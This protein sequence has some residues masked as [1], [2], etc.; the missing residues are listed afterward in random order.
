MEQAANEMTSDIRTLRDFLVH[1]PRL[2]NFQYNTTV[3]YF[4]WKVLFACLRSNQDSIDWDKLIGV[5]ST[6]NWKK[7]VYQNIDLPESWRETFFDKA[8][9]N[10]HR[11]SSCSRQC[12]PT[13]TVYYC[14]DCTKNPLY[15]ICEQCFDKSK[16]STHR[17]TSRVVTRSEGRVCHCGDPS[18]FT[19]P[20][21]AHKCINE[22]NNEKVDF[23]YNKEEHAQSAFSQVL[24][25]L[26]DVLIYLK[27]QSEEYPKTVMSDT[28]G[29][30]ESTTKHYAL[31]LY[32]D[33]CKIHVLDLTHKISTI[34]NKPLE[35]GTMMVGRLESGH[36]FVTLVESS[37]VDKLKI[38]QQAFATD[39]ISLHLKKTNDIFKEYLIEELLEWCYEICLHNPSL[40]TK[41][42]LRVSICDAWNSNL[43]S[44]KLTPDFLS[45]YI[46]KI[47]LL[48]KFTVP[49]EQ[50]DSFPWCKPWEFS[51]TADTS[52]DPQILEIM[53]N[54]D[55]RLQNTDI[56]HTLSKFHPLH[57]SRF[58]YLLS[59][60]VPYIP[61]LSKF[62]IQKVFC[63]IFTI[64]DD[65]RK[66]LA[67]QYLDIYPTLLFNTVASD[68]SGYQVS[69]M[70]VLSQYIFQNP[71][72]ANMV[73]KCGFIERLLQFT[74]TL[75]SFTPEELIDCPPVPL[76]RGF[77][78][79]PDTIKNK[80]SVICF[81]DIYLTMS[82][83]TVPEEL[84]T[85]KTIIG[86]IV[87]SFSTFDTVLP[88]KREAS[89]HVEFENFEFSSYYFFF[90]SM[91]AMVDG[92]V[93][94]IC[95]LTDPELRREIVS[96]FLKMS[97][98]K[99]F[100]LLGAFRKLTS[101]SASSSEELRE[102]TTQDGLLIVKEKICNV[103]SNVVNYQVG[104]DIQNFFNPMSYFFRF[105]LQW[106]QCGRYE[107]LP[108]EIKGYF[109]FSK[110]FNNK[111]HLIWISESALST[112]VMI[113]Q[114]SVGFWVRNG[115]PITHQLR[116][117]TKYSMREFTYF[118]DIFNVQFS[119]SLADPND[120]MV[121][122]LSRWGL[123][124]WTEGVPM[125]DYP[126]DD[127]TAAMVDQCL[128]LIIRL[129]TE[130]RS[131]VMTSSVEGFE[132]TMQT[133]IIHA[134]CFNSFSHNSLMNSIPE[135][136]TKHPAF[137]LYLED[138]TNYTPPSGLMDAGVYTLKEEYQLQIDP[139]FIGFPPSKR[140][141][142]E[143]MV[144][145]GMA[146]RDG[147]EYKDTFVPPKEIAECLKP[148][149]YSQLYQISN[150]D[151]FGIFLK[152]TLD[153]IN[154]FK[155]ETMLTKAVH[156][157]HLCVI[158]N[159]HGFMKIF[160]RE[161]AFVHTEFS[162]YHSIGSLLY[163]FLLK[164][165]FA[166]EHGKIREIFKFLRYDAPHINIDS[167]L[168][169][170]TP[171][172]NPDLLTR[173]GKE[174]HEKDDEFEKK[175]KLAKQRKKKLMR[176]LAKQ[177]QMFMENNSMSTAISEPTEGTVQSKKLV[178]RPGWSYPADICIF[179]KMP[180]DDDAFVYFSFLENNICDQFVNFSLPLDVTK[181]Y[182]EPVS[183]DGT[184]VYD[185]YTRFSG[186]TFEGKLQKLQTYEN[187]FKNPKLTKQRHVLRTCGHGAHITC[188]NNHMKSARATHNHITK[189]LPI[190]L[191]FSLTFCPLCNA[192]SNC[193]L[194]K[195]ASTNTRRKEDLLERSNQDQTNTTS[196]NV[197][198][199]CIRALIVLHDLISDSHKS[200]MVDPIATLT[201]IIT[202]TVSNIEIT[203]RFIGRPGVSHF[204]LNQISNQN[205]MTLRILSELKIF[206]LENQSQ[207]S[208]TLYV[209]QS[210]LQAPFN[211]K[212]WQSFIQTNFD[213]DILKLV[214]LYL[215]P[216]F[217]DGATMPEVLQ[218]LLKKKL[219]QEFSSISREL[220]K[221]NFYMPVTKQEDE[222]V[223]SLPIT[224]N[225]KYKM[226][227]EYVM[228]IFKDY[229][230][231]FSP[232]VP[233]EF[234]SYL[235]EFKWHFH[236][237]IIKSLTV[238]MRR[239]ILLIH[240]EYAMD[241]ECTDFPENYRELDKLL[242]FCHLFTVQSL[243]EHYQKYELST[244]TTFMNQAIWQLQKKTF[245]ERLD[246]MNICYP[247][248]VRLIDLPKRLSSFT[249][250]EDEHIKYRA[251]KRELAICLF[252]GARAHVQSSVGIHNHSIGEC[253]N[254]YYNQCK[255]NSSYGCFLLVRSGSIYLAYGNRGTFYR[256]PY[257][258]KHGDTDED[259]RFGTTL[260]LNM[261]R[262]TH[263]TRDV[264]LSNMIP[265]LVFRL[266]DNTS[267]LGGW[268]SM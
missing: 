10:D 43:M 193:F 173:S 80:R 262:Y 142:A 81:K 239:S 32:E 204:I 164:E 247:G 188:L 241:Q 159:L 135:H 189:N 232:T 144:R 196:E 57:G 172:F 242:E 156:L 246:K 209:S 62:R 48:G 1:L 186:T 14:F 64:V 15:E 9:N 27:E 60:V 267:D 87:Q 166:N 61:K 56:P 34:L 91:L 104:V 249:V 205:L 169:E 45:P 220:M 226:E 132:K 126:D 108:N 30:L 217:R 228:D 176:K 131:L 84:L 221:M 182:S 261:E 68:T 116:M 8:L 264:V 191:G 161:Y 92:F 240:S 253:T 73:I 177:Q 190:T 22:S 238:F 150:T 255:V 251:H 137:D 192:L 29:R 227:V 244:I 265:H 46:T 83:N 199:T 78:L 160:W 230:S 250:N 74:F 127:T 101:D 40:S 258:N 114:I 130:V 105:V 53:F 128:L 117:Y 63:I 198:A 39:G 66:C 236:D 214:D 136:V 25:Y 90:S 2:A 235:E 149:L 202:N 252:C 200:N 13:E 44:T 187:C 163:S 158:N 195:I 234:L 4:L 89:E 41:L 197:Y 120:F 151:I 153:H 146:K 157:V 52:H 139:Y 243:F 17:F 76:C 256:A 211:L 47:S 33:E 42:A 16:H 183:L 38:I 180:H 257:L 185:N 259:Y 154:K 219:H 171:S 263:L 181:A 165:E 31:Q 71:S 203:S 96:Q 168:S 147:I 58:Q 222:L 6:E 167:Y 12:H 82:T 111:D 123:K 140:Y 110:F 145:N 75:M 124:N 248:S 109:N 7:G 206:I 245:I 113:S 102:N 184:N 237:M 49:Y 70:S 79:P 51:N 100:E 94:N 224:K 20:N 266:T 254:H 86:A 175:K 88:L 5:F 233:E 65:S 85:N 26:I 201:Y 97:M 72:I 122:Y 218:Q 179:C 162:Y 231:V 103:V 35:F 170:Q 36:P 24:D 260:T 107:P 55:K 98:L 143:K 28:K 216:G 213:Y 115:T 125:G 155:Y 3:S 141:E 54:Y 112:L 59:E 133:E 21:N 50:R 118:S 99:E 210:S 225:Q 212:D 95:L 129:L 178:I 174:T 152:N 77:K 121:S 106:S 268:E 18:G 215:E 148:T 229:I 67:A 19:D 138:L 207:V 37:D 119:M 223:W 11:G 194:P 208:N 134:L 23:P 69:L 93:R